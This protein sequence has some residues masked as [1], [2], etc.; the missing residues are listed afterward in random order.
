MES[1]PLWVSGIHL[2]EGGTPAE[3]GPLRLCL[4][5]CLV[6][7]TPAASAHGPAGDIEIWALSLPWVLWAGASG[8][9]GALWDG[10][11]GESHH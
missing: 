7:F 9:G 3:Q 1:W 11:E 8:A 5:G 6:S 4:W 2:S 10:I